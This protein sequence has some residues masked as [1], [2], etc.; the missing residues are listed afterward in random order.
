MKER[1][2]FVQL[3]RTKVW[4]PKNQAKTEASAV[5]EEFSGNPLCSDDLLHLAFVAEHDFEPSIEA[6]FMK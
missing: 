1:L 6:R 2:P 3:A 5:Y 4:V